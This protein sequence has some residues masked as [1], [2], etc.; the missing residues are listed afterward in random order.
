MNERTGQT[1]VYAAIGT[2]EHNRLVPGPEDARHDVTDYMELG[3]WVLAQT[4]GGQNM[5][6]TF[7]R[8]AKPFPKEAYNDVTLGRTF[9]TIDAYHIIERLTEVF[10]L[11]GQG[12][13]VAVREWH[14]DGQNLA[15]DGVLWYM[16]GEVRCEVEA[17]GDAMVIRGNVAEARKKARTNLISKAAS[18]LGC[19]LSVYQGRGVDDPYLDREHA[20]QQAP[21]PS[22][23]LQAAPAGTD[24]VDAAWV[25]RLIDLAVKHHVTSQELTDKLAGTWNGTPMDKLTRDQAKEL[26]EWIKGEK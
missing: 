8:F 24:I 23:R 25:R 10:G 4:E 26:A 21:T 6:E 14:V 5:N 16:A 7:Q 22:P 11:C 1:S 2:D 9:T 18:Y 12:W 3:R 19:G 13:G 17:T 20:A 15:A